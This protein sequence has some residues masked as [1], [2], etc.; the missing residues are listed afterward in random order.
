MNKFGSLIRKLRQEHKESITKIASDLK[1]TQPYICNIENGKKRPPSYLADFYIERYN[2]KGKKTKA[3]KDALFFARNE[4]KVD[5]KGFKEED[6]FIIQTIV[7]DY[8]KHKK[9]LKE[10]IK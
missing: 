9:Q 1:V 10:M 8:K 2:L 5:I 4:D 3:I 7:K 6:K